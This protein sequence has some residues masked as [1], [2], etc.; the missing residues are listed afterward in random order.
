[1]RTHT[2]IQELPQ[3]YDFAPRNI[4]WFSIIVPEATRNL[5]KNPI[6]QRD[7][8]GYSTAPSGSRIERTDEKQR[9]GSHSLKI[10]YAL[11]RRVAYNPYISTPGRYT[12]SV[13]IYM[14]R[15]RKSPTYPY[16]SN[17]IK[18]SVEYPSYTVLAS[19]QYYARGYWDRVI[20]SFDAPAAGT[21][22]IAFFG[23]GGALPYLSGRTIAYID[24][25]QLE[26][27]PYATTLCHGDMIGD[28]Y[29][30]KDYW[31]LGVPHASFS[32]RSAYC[33]TGGREMNFFE[34]GLRTLSIIGIGIAG[35]GNILTPTTRGSIYGGSIQQDRTF[36]I[37]AERHYPQANIGMKERQAIERL[38]SP[39][40]TS[41]HQPLML[42]YQYYDEC[43]KIDGEE[44]WIKCL[45]ESGL[46]GSLDNYQERVGM[47]YR[48]YMPYI[49]TGG[50]FGA[51]LDPA[52]TET[53]TNPHAISSG[54][55]V[56]NL[57]GEWVIS[58][59]FLGDASNT[60]Y[61]L[62]TFG[63]YLYAG[64]RFGNCNG[65]ANTTQL[66]RYD[67]ETQEWE[68]VPGFDAL[69]P[70][71][72]VVSMKKSI[73]NKLYVGGITATAFWIVEID[74]DDNLTLLASTP[75][76]TT[77]I[78][79]FG[80][81]NDGT[82]YCSGYDTGYYYVY[83]Y[84]HDT[85]TWSRVE[86]AAGNLRYGFDSYV[87]DIIVGI[88]GRVYVTGDF[89]EDNTSTYTYNGIVVADDSET[90]GWAMLGIS[91]MSNPTGS[92]LGYKLLM[93]KD[94]S[95]YAA[96]SFKSI[97]G[98]SNTHGIANWNGY[99]WQA[100]GSGLQPPFGIVGYTVN[101]IEEDEFGDIYI[102]TTVSYAVGLQSSN[103]LGYT[104]LA[105]KNSTWM[106]YEINLGPGAIGSRPI[107]RAL[108]LYN[109]YAFHAFS[110]AAATLDVN[111]NSSN[112]VTYSA[113]DSPAIVDIV[114][115]GI[116]IG[117]GSF[118]TGEQLAFELEVS[119][120]EILVLRTGEMGLELI[121]NTRGDLTH[122][123]LPGSSSTLTLKNGTNYISVLYVNTTPFVSSVTIYCDK[124][125]QALSGAF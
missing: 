8:E 15:A 99:N 107:S 29:P 48:I 97:D 101:D 54:V 49:A 59:E 89:T 36:T 76:A 47:T 61:E 45:Y 72:F 67:L 119:I 46:E 18:I 60:V 116:L 34:L 14:E 117:L 44:L 42:K 23:D 114:G 24:G 35:I 63:K 7:D 51:E 110:T 73:D 2:R 118:T 50:S 13:Y 92:V 26:N 1:M 123:I 10:E 95:L 68:A 106:P 83:E 19:K 21:Y 5:I 20:L 58:A 28:A 11:P 109:G 88:D 121:S 37:I 104:L 79:Y 6:L 78:K 122:E 98:L 39:F 85:D 84:D 74:L 16:L 94:G 25:L 120:G 90:S 40:I 82:L 31:W 125:Y 38:M 9:F 43:S 55:M 64:G 17:S 62:E 52:V 113:D 105:W 80:V 112:A 102:A 41:P 115:P 32:E 96:G 30:R 70:G 66:A 108:A 33:R 12:F 53:F 86:T 3:G 22:T 56:R 124:T 103:L 71:G 69:R 111:S 87:R 4:D 65:L 75:G 27:K 57:I 77:F 81:G 91:G 100:L 93:A